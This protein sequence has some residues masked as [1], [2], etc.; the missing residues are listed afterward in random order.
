M[1]S[2]HVC[3]WWLAYAFDNPLR[4]LFHDPHKILADYVSEGMTVMDIGCGMGFFSLG[5]AEL[6]GDDGKVIAVDLQQEMLDITLKR[7]QKKGLAQ[8]IRPH[9]AESDS[10]NISTRVDFIMAFWMVHE[11]PD[12]SALFNE[13]AAVLRPTAKLFYAEPLFHVPEKR[14]R[15]LLA[16]ADRAGLRFSRNL[17]IRFSHAALLEK[18]S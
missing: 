13:A 3:P 18:N 12:P 11:V 7:A 2:I 15:E 14:F 9:R 10:I 8:R 4:R 6:V 5:L 16:E 1:S 17:S